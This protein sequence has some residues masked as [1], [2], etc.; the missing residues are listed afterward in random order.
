MTPIPGTGELLLYEQELAARHKVSL[1]KLRNDRWLGRGVPFIKIGR[2]VRYRM[3]DVLAY[4]A[5]HFRTSTSD[6]GPA[7]A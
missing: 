2:L 7:H 6:G 4:E 3:S 1:Q 5:A